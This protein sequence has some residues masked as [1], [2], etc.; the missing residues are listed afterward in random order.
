MEEENKVEVP[1][2][3]GDA[4]QQPDAP[5]EMGHIEAHI[6]DEQDE[7]LDGLLEAALEDVASSTGELADSS[8]DS[9]GEYHECAEDQKQESNEGQVDM[10]HGCAHYRRHCEVQAP[11]CGEWFSCRLCH[12]KAKNEDEP[13]FK[14]QHTVDRHA[15]ALVRCLMCQHEQPPSHACANCQ[16]VLGAYFCA[17]CNLF[18]HRTQRDIFHCVECGICR[19]G[20]RDNF[21]H[22]S[23]CGMCLGMGLRESHKCFEQVSRLVSRPNIPCE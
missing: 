8:S 3:M 11:C 22:C 16:Q 20:G 9:D 12:D 4:S 6:A 15:I 19:V 13:D 10:S 17:V 18:E 7:D 1:L 2:E 23:K 21:F 14:K 5:L